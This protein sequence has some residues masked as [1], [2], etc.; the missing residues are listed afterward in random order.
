M[1]HTITS[2]LFFFNTD[3]DYL[4]YYK[5]YSA[6]IDE[7]QTLADLLQAYVKQIRDYS[8]DSLVSVNTVLVDDTLSIKSLVENFGCDI[9]IE[10][11]SIYRANKDL[12]INKDDFIEKISPLA[13]FCD[14]NDSDYYKSQAKAY[15]ASSS[16]KHNE[17]YMGDALFLLA[18]RLIHKDA[19]NKD[20]ILNI[21][22]DAENGLGSFE[23]ENN[24][25][26]ALNIEKVIAELREMTKQKND[27]QSPL[28]LMTKKIKAK[29]YPPKEVIILTLKDLGHIDFSTLKLQKS[30][31]GFNI[32]S[33][34]NPQSKQD[35]SVLL[36]FTGANI[37]NFAFENKASGL[38]ILDSSPKTA[39]LK[40]ADIIVDAFDQS[41]DILV[42][43][44]EEERLHLSSRKTRKA[45]GRDID[46]QIITASQLLEIALGNTDKKSLG[47][48]KANIS[49]I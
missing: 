16:L 1:Q 34:T 9:E 32:A 7:N 28:Q 17:D 43:A 21:I 27:R 44:S 36:S 6:T 24:T 26:P 49:F 41:A 4:P 12:Q 47:L 33:Y 3:T 23:I 19:T 37:I 40:G 25:L 15:Y 30:F 46:L 42:V 14:A 13:E 35:Y 48:E 38:T 29:I 2:R 45:S 39:V 20:L 31:K 22:N 10:P 18:F 8:V 5:S 11:I